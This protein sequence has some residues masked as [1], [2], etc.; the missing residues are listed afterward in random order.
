M[1][2]PATPKIV[3]R[4]EWEQARAELLVRE[5]AHTHAGDELAAARRRLPMTRMEPVMVVGRNG[6]VPLADVFEGRRRQRADD[7][8]RRRPPLLPSGR[9]RGVPD[10]RN[11]VARHRGHAAHATVARPHCLRPAGDLGGL[12]RWLAAGQGWLVVAA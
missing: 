8:N 10:I 3:T 11:E 9:R 5:K 7:P 4:D 6:P 1:T 12:A 2:D